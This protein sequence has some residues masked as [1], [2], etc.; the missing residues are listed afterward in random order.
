MISADHKAFV[1]KTTGQL[2]GAAALEIDNRIVENTASDRRGLV[3]SIQG[4]LVAAEK[5]LGYLYQASGEISARVTEVRNGLLDTIEAPVIKGIGLGGQ[6]QYLIQ[7]PGLITG[8][9]FTRVRVYE[10][11]LAEVYGMSPD[12]EDPFTDIASPGQLRNAA[13][14]QESVLL[15]AVTAI[16]L[17]IIEAPVD[18]R[19]DALALINRLQDLYQQAL[20]ELE[21]TQTLLLSRNISYQYFSADIG[22]S[23]VSGTCGYLIELSRTLAIEKRFVLREARATIEIV[24]TEHKAIDPYYDRFIKNNGLRGNE[25]LIL[26]AGRGV[27][28]YA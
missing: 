23:A 6:L 20:S 7:L 18:N 24:I 27:R 25:I 10:D 1:R 28:V 8:D 16:C 5:T 2:N 14:I 17:M 3:A 26:P 22:V 11:L 19:P 15:S 12:L 4:V 13:T 9:I 21:K